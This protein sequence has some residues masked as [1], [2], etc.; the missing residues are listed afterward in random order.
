M[1]STSESGSL[2]LPISEA[3]DLLLGLFS[4]CVPIAFAREKRVQRKIGLPFVFDLMRVQTL[5]AEKSQAD[6]R[7]RILDRQTSVSGS[8][9]FD[10]RVDNPGLLSYCLEKAGPT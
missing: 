6:P 4:R 2:E 5:F 10:A 9:L 7:L 1:R 8:A 3:D